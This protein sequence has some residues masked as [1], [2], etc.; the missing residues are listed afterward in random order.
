ME[1]DVYVCFRI[2]VVVLQ[3]PKKPPATVDQA[4][5]KELDKEVL[6]YSCFS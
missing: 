2:I 5:V 3:P 1:D 4:H 6:L